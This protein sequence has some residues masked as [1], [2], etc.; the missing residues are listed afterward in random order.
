MPANGA[1]AGLILLSEATGRR[2]VGFDGRT[3]GRVADLSVDLD[4]QAGPP[5]VQRLL[6]RRRHANDLLLPWVVIENV[7]VDEISVRAGADAGAFAV[8]AVEDA[9]RRHEI[10]LVRDVLDTQIVDVV[11]RRLARVAD[12]ALTGVAGERLALLGVE[13]GFGGVLR[14]L[15]L[16][17]LSS[18][19]RRDIVEW[20]DLHLTSD[21]G[22]TVQLATPRSAVHHLDSAGLAAVVERLDTEAAAE[23]LAATAPAVAA[24]VIRADPGVGERVL[25][26]MPASN[27][28]AIV[29]EMPA[30]HAARWHARLAGTPVLRGRRFLRSHVWPRRRHRRIGPTT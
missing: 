9:L 3:I 21:R 17:R 19:T 24:G 22:H 7:A 23:V 18:R 28:T 16:T 4:S 30:E 13:V 12:I 15:G 1:P 8:D 14:R 2:V 25:R 10:L 11:G 27:A 20:N 26:A 29:A 6:V 5:Q